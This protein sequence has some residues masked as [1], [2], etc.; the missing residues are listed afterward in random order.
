MGEVSGASCA[1][2]PLPLVHIVSTGGTIANTA[3]G[4]I[5]IEDVIRAVPAVEALGRFSVTETARV[6]SEFLVPADW[7][8]IARA[9][10]AA[11][12]ADE[13][14][15]VVVTHGTYTNEETAYFLHLV[16]PTDKPVVVV[17]SQRK[18]GSLGNDGD[19]N[20]FDAVRVALSPAARGI[21]VVTL[22]NEDIH[23]ARDV[24]KTSPR[25]DGFQSRDVGV[26]GHA[27]TDRVV[28]YRTPTRRHTVR[29]EFAIGALAEL[30]R[31]DVVHAYP[32]ADE[33]TVTALLD[34]ARPAG[35]VVAGFAFNGTP[36]PG[37]QLDALAAAVQAGIPVVLANRGLGGRVPHPGEQ[38]LVHGLGFVSGDNLAPHKARI[39]LMLGLTRSADPAELQRLFDEY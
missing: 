12:A 23:S 31:V 19:R 21:G 36:A 25:P 33:H 38:S 9:V 27:D 4:R 15:G 2:S 26:L 37:G 24:V 8:D 6:G 35:I 28:V 20:L 34:R 1:D 39:L 17:S 32:G 29:S 18:H 30:P 11:A 22:L 7:L 3:S 16:V 14:T 5:A 10:A 13:V